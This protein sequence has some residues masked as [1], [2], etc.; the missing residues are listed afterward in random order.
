VTGPTVLFV[1]RLSYEANVHGLLWFVREC[2]PAIRAAL[3]DARLRVVGSGPP[4]AVRAL[5]GDGVEL[6]P[7]APEVEPHYAAATVAIAPIFRGTGVQMKLIQS[8]AA[9]VPT[10]TTTTVATRA[11][12][13]DGT[14]VRVADDRDGWV[15]AVRGLLRRDADADRLATAG[16]D[17]AVA[18][19]GTTA[20]RRQLNAAYEAVLGRQVLAG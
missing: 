16:R 10:V 4:R 15:D 2:W 3:P 14:Q 13:R 20:V 9:G 18:N 17:W 5:V 11:G 12:V 8:L 19:H 6:F 7:D 1:G